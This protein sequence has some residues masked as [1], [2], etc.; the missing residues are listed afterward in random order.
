MYLALRELR[1][2]WV[3]FAILA[4]AIA[5][6]MFLILFQQ[7]I[8]IGLVNSFNGA[9]RAQ[10]APVLVFSVDGQRSLQGSV[11]TPNVEQAVAAVDGVADIGRIGLATLTVRAADDVVTISLFGYSDPDLGA[12]TSLVAGRLPD[13]DREGVAVASAPEQGFEVGDTVF[14]QPGGYDITIV[15][16]AEGIDYQATTTVFTSFDSYTAAVTSANPGAKGVLPSALP[17]IPERGL[18][19][20]EVVD[21]INGSVDGADAA[22]RANAADTT[23]GVAEVGRS[24]QLIF[25]LYGLVVPL[26]TGL[27]FLIMTLQKAESLTLLR[28][29][30]APARWLVSS[31]L[32]EV[33]L[34]VV[35]GLVLGIAGYVP[36][37]NANLGGIQLSFQGGAAAGWSTVILALAIASAYFSARRVLRIDPMQATTGAGVEL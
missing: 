25:A 37:S 32:F 34:V 29:V 18:S 14:V 24:F 33:V 2:S 21:R 16:L 4:F 6:L 15:G 19:S 30:G 28:A 9:I 8:Q 3:R 36:L 13:G 35:G 17:V 26:V 27:F 7:T 1:R 12:P 22:T 23:P 20:S 10:S 11:I 31:I 5:L